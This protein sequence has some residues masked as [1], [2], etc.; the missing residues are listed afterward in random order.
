MIGRYL[1]NKRGLSEYMFERLWI[2]FILTCAFIIAIFIV[3]FYIGYILS[4][5]T[6]K[7]GEIKK[8]YVFEITVKKKNGLSNIT[9]IESDETLKIIKYD[10]N[11]QLIITESGKNKF[12]F[13]VGNDIKID[14]VESYS[15]K[16][17]YK[18]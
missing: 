12:G 8:N 6:T 3:V 4:T 5:D 17:K 2:G 10:F 1:R 11:G 16:T 15:L 18:K 9:T 14:N 13:K 7:P